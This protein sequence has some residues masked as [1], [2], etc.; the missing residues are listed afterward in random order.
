MFINI[1][2]LVL[3][4]FTSSFSFASQWFEIDC[5]KINKNAD[6]IHNYYESEK[7]WK[8]ADS[9]VQAWAFDFNDGEVYLWLDVQRI[10]D[11]NTVWRGDHA[12]TSIKTDNIKELIAD[13]NL[14]I[15]QQVDSGHSNIRSSN[16]K[17]KFNYRNFETSDGIGFYG[18][19][20]KLKTFF[21]FGFF[22][23][24]KN[25][26]LDENFISE[27]L[28][29]LN[30]STINKGENSSIRPTNTSNS[31]NNTNSYENIE[32]QKSSNSEEDPEAFVKFCKNSKLADLDDEV[33][34]LCLNKMYN[35]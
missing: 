12:Y 20:S 35:E 16:G 14:G 3:L 31:F 25:S 28:S 2:S 26:I 33:A 7:C 27:I 22:T 29:S 24:N 11:A 6:I 23:S 1:I 5:N 30:I 8:A 19:Q 4:L 32:S 10:I 21:T 34:I 17:I 15:S 13:F 18:G 9:S